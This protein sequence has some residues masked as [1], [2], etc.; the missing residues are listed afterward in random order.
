MPRE[1]STTALTLVAKAASEDIPNVLSEMKVCAG[2][3]E[4]RTRRKHR[5]KVVNSEAGTASSWYCKDRM[6]QG[7]RL[8]TA[9]GFLLSSR[10]EILLTLY[11]LIALRQLYLE[12]QLLARLRVIS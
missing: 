12:R 11:S 6:R 3:A 10:Y 9:D 4:E 7:A 1:D 5:T 8:L 2:F